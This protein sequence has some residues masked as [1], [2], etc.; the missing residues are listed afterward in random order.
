MVSYHYPL[1]FYKYSGCGNDFI[2]I[3]D[4]QGHL[5]PSLASHVHELC[6]RHE[7]IGADGVILIQAG[8]HDSDVSIKHYNPDGSAA[9]Q[10]GNG[11]RCL[12][13]CLHDDLGIQKSHFAIATDAGIR[14]ARLFDQE[15]E[16]ELGDST[17]IQGPFRLDGCP[18]LIAYSLR[19]GNPHL[20]LVVEDLEE[21]NVQSLGRQ[22]RFS[23]QFHPE[24]TNVHFATQIG[25]SQIAVRTYE[26][27]VEAETLACGTGCAASA[28][29]MSIV[30][31]MTCPVDTLTRGGST[32]SYKFKLDN[33]YAK[34]ITMR[35]EA[36]RCYQG[37]YRLPLAP[38]Q[39]KH[40]ET[41]REAPYA[42]YS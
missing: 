40:I 35:G 39:N 8:R 22:L 36:R 38:V 25:P 16:I 10:C 6:H 26:R 5:P 18:D 13:R 4:R 24:G 11:L 23:P 27:G 29:V 14:L 17:P 19:I 28:I 31:N 30:G 33:A 32:L 41:L 42:L 15:I 12:V 9:E 1:A 7:G 34:S 3:D 21:I 2:I 20:V 37:L